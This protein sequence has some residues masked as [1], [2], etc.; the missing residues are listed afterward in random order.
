MST[1]KRTALV[2]RIA[3]KMREYGMRKPVKIPKHSFIVSDND[4]HK[5]TFNVRSS[6]KEVLYTTEDVAKFL[7]VFVETIVNAIK[8][9]ESVMLF[10]FGTFH[11]KTRA[12]S[13]LKDFQS[14]QMIEVPEHY[15]LKFE[16]GE[17]LKTA[18][19][20]YN[21]GVEE[22]VFE[23]ADPN[24]IIEEDDDDVAEG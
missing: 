2:S 23:H 13:K 6:D 19:K 10:G 21:V 18:I 1:V 16:I 5:A 24:R 3:D 4:G 11:V 9:G 8:Q 20:L 22:G 17:M 14:G 15:C 12:P 7:D